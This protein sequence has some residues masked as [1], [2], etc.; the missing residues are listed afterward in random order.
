MDRSTLHQSGQE[1]EVNQSG[2]KPGFLPIKLTPH[3]SGGGS[4]GPECPWPG[5][6]IAV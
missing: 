6:R 1:Q 5:G 3:N 2:Q 4:A